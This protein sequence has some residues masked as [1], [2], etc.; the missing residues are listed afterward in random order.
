[1]DSVVNNVHPVDLV[2]R[3]EVAVKALFNVFDNGPPRVVIIDKVT[4]A[5]GINHGET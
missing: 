2:L 5:W 4:K 1:M 3:I